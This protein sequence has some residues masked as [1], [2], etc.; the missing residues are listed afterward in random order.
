MKTAALVDTF[1]TQI[2]PAVW[3]S[4]GEASWESGRLRCNSTTSYAG[5]YS[6]TSYD[7]HESSYTV[8]VVAPPAAASRETSV[9]LTGAGGNGATFAVINSP[10][11]LLM[12]RKQS[13]N[14]D[15][16]VTYDPAAHA[17]LRLRLTGTTLYFDASPNGVT[18]TNLNALS[19]TADLSA[20]E[21]EM[22]VG[23]WA[24]ES[25]VQPGYF[26]NVNNPPAGWPEVWSGSAWVK[27]PA[28][29]WSGSAWVQ[30]PVKV[31]TGS[32][33]KPVA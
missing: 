6:L 1:A 27:K 4:Y 10:R 24:A 17:W 11:Q 15:S 3:G 8:Q 19:M 14:T 16:T 32:T 22:S 20:C 25:D 7:L 30:K 9:T 28:K 29:V 23:Q 2:D 5:V 26:D 18:W 33:W 12:R 21:I 13:G 31:W